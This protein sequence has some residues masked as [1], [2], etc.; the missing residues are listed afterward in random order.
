MEMR[1]KHRRS[2]FGRVV[3]RLMAII[4]LGLGLPGC[5]S[6]GPPAHRPST[7]APSAALVY[8]SDAMLAWE[9][10]QAPPDSA[11]FEFARNDAILGGGQPVALRATNQWPETLL[12]IERPVVFRLFQQD[13]GSYSRSYDRRFDG[14]SRSGQ[15]YDRGAYNR[16]S[17]RSGRGSDR[18][19]YNGRYQ[20]RR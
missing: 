18:G 9:G 2:R 3:F 8:A 6:S 1:K 4:P 10:S 7:L 20:G 12:P 5:A 19:A 17:D 11:R 13:L 15:G 16:D 14:D